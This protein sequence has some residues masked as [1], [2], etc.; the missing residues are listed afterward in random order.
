MY[1]VIPTSFERIE[2]VNKRANS[3]AK[4]ILN[5]RHKTIKEIFKPSE[6][7]LK[8]KLRVGNIICYRFS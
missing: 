2:F 5:T 6:K 3:T 1:V 7:S 4:T 8:S